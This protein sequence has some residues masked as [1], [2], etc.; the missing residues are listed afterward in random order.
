MVKVPE[1]LVS[2][3]QNKVNDNG[4]FVDEPTLRFVGELVEALRDLTLHNRS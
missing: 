3:A 2:E 4:E 1:V